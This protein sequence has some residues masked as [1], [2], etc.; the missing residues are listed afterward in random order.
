[1][2]SGRGTQRQPSTRGCHAQTRLGVSATRENLP[3]HAANS[4]GRT[5]AKI[6]GSG[7][8]DS[9]FGASDTAAALRSVHGP[10]TRRTRVVGGVSTRRDPRD[11]DVP[12]TTSGDTEVPPHAEPL[13]VGVV[14]AGPLRP[15]EMRGRQDF[16]GHGGPAHKTPSDSRDGDVPPTVSLTRSPPTRGM[17]TSRPQHY[18]PPT[19]GGHRLSRV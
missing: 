18:I 14:W 19:A 15:A 2:T 1:M 8:H 3:T 11:G 7:L 5:P 13:W 12:P 16:A 4:S 6:L 9:L 10:L 17:G